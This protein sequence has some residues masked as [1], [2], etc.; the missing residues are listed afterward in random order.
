[1][2]L[3]HPDLHLFK[4]LHQD[5]PSS[6]LEL[7]LCQKSLLLRPTQGVAGE[8]RSFKILQHH[9]FNMTH[10]IYRLAGKFWQ[11]ECTQS[12]FLTLPHPMQGEV[13]REF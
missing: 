9:S 2:T 5:W 7:V 4:A 11:V 8:E 12:L 1:M 10:L 6:A 3:L 13:R